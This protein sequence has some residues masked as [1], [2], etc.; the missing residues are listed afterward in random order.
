MVL[1]T[2]LGVGAELPE[3]LRTQTKVYEQGMKSYET[4][5]EAQVNVARETYRAQLTAGRRYAEGGKRLKETAAIDADLGALKAGDLSA[6]APENLPADLLGHRERC[7]G[8]RARAEAS[9][10]SS[11]RFARENHRKWLKD[12]GAVAARGKDAKL[13]A[14]VEAELARLGKDATPEPPKPTP[15]AK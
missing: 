15:S 2:R 3:P 10:A 12:M 5:V 1:A 9:V 6:T 11:R 8:A 14:A 13:A 4:T 7:R